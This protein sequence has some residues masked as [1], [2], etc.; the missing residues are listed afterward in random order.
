MVVYSLGTSF[1]IQFLRARS[2]WSIYELILLFIHSQSWMKIKVSPMLTH[3]SIWSVPIKTSLKRIIS[4][5][6]FIATWS[7]TESLKFW[8]CSCAYNKSTLNILSP[9]EYALFKKKHEQFSIA[10]SIVKFFTPSF[11]YAIAIL[12]LWKLKKFFAIKGEQPSHICSFWAGTYL[13]L[14]KKRISGRSAGQFGQYFSDRHKLVNIADGRLSKQFE[15]LKK[16]QYLYV[17]A[18][19]KILFACCFE[20]I[21]KLSESVNRPLSL[22]VQK[23]FSFSMK[24]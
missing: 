14:I 10:F 11:L 24:V 20:Y 3:P 19:R 18:I 6:I 4:L 2:E 8:K 13:I 15:Q 9:C 12:F 7:L 23:R 21:L 1:S 5:W 22:F 17:C 16:I